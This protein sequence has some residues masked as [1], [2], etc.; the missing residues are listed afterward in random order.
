VFQYFLRLAEIAR[1][2]AYH[3]YPWRKSVEGNAGVFGKFNST[4][5]L[6]C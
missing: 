1:G 5:Q 2:D 6:P 3:L 4:D